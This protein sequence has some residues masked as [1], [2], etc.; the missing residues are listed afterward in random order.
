M[1]RC[2]YNYDAPFRF[3]DGSEFSGLTLV[4]HRSEGPVCGRKVIWIFHALTANSDPTDW[5]PGLV[6]RGKLIDTD[7]FFVVCCNMLGSCYGSSGPSCISP[8][9]G[10]S[11]YF[12]FPQITVRDIVRSQD[13]VRQHL[14]L[15]H[16]DFLLG[17]S[18]GG[19]QA[20]EYSIM[21][22]SVVRNALFM[23]TLPRV[24]PWLTA[25]EEAQRMALESDP[26]FRAAESLQGGR[27]AL[28]CARAIA[29]LSYR[30]EEGL[31]RKQ[32]DPDPDQLI[33]GRASSYMQHQGCK[34]VDRFD[35]YSYWYLTYSLDSHNVGRDRGGVA[36]A[37][38][39]ITARTT[40]ISIDSDLLFPPYEMEEMAREIPGSSYY[41]IT[42]HYGH[43]GFL[44]ENDQI[45]AL[46]GPI[47]ESL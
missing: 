47:L 29:L 33:A 19:F 28:K 43:D 14:G 36:A 20:L 38:K 46:V 8:A 40:V 6:G 16:I 4:Y 35:A 31:N 24:T 26:S 5:W 37:L 30:C 1:I 39:C 12:S 21:F 41:Q 2:T 42:S 32:S 34:F 45:S 13:L 23:A 11:F 22:P 9:T 17:S 15:E 3:E 10:K 25:F 7:R 27:E 44:L 18:I